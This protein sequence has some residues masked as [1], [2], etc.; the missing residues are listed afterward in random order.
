MELTSWTRAA[1]YYR[2]DADRETMV[3]L[4]LQPE[5][6]YD[7]PAD[8]FSEEL[9]VKSHDGTL[10]PLSVRGLKTFKRDGS[11]PLW[12]KATVP[13]ASWM[14]HFFLRR[15]LPPSNMECGKQWRTSGAEEQKVTPGIA[16][17]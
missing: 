16:L 14:S 15:C 4:N 8:L 1:S 13:M 6:P 17:E 5:G 9:K 2:Y 11:H 7:H 12:R 10:V 3:A